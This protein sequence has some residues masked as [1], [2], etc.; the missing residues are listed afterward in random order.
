MAASA[1]AS[2]ISPAA[3]RRRT[4]AASTGSAAAAASRK[5]AMTG[6][7]RTG[8]GSASRSIARAARTAALS[9]RGI[10]PWPHVPVMWIR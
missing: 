9:A 1:A 3:I 6:V 2:S 5:R 10:E 7:I 8:P 4:V